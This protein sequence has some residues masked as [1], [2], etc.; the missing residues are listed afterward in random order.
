MSETENVAAAKRLYE[1]VFTGGDIAVLNSIAIDDLV[2]HDPTMKEFRGGLQTFKEREAMFFNAFPDKKSTIDDLI[3]NGDKVVVRWTTTGTHQNEL[4][5]VA[6]TLKPINV[7]GISILRFDNGKIA[8]IW[9]YWDE[10]ALLNQLGV[11]VPKVAA[12]TR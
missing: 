8:E 9:Q 11:Q 3:P 4:P 6:P 7:S 12:E 1:E 5:G 2:F 10:L